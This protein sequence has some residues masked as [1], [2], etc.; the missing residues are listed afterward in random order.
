MSI[1]YG[2]I[3]RRIKEK[4]KGCLLTQEMLA[5]KLGVSVGYISQLERGITRVNLDTLSNI[6]TELNCD[7]TCFLSDV[8][9]AD[10]KFLRTELEKVL[11]KMTPSQ[12]KMLFEI[13]E[14]IQNN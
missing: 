1:D 4:R 12:R 3:G 11:E 8:S 13:A 10:K 2:I 6:A 5:E 7:I 14:I 9:F